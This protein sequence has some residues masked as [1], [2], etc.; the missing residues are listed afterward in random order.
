[1]DVILFLLA[2]FDMQA[3]KEKNKARLRKEFVETFEGTEDERTLLTSFFIPLYMT[4]GE[5][6]GV[7]KEHEIMQIEYPY[8]AKPSSEKPVHYS[9]IFNSRGKQKTEIL[10]VMTKGIAGIGKTV[11][12]HI[13]PKIGRA[14]C[15]ER[16]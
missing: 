15:R 8:K 4:T 6:E 14:S 5:S 13:H 2:V 9:D 7:N 10:T 12:V 16:V 3:F 11:S 1:M